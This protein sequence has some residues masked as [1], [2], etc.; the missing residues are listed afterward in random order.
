MYQPISAKQFRDNMAQVLEEVHE[1]GSEYTLI[2]R[3][4]PMVDIVPSKIK[5]TG[6]ANKDRRDFLEI[7][8]ENLGNTSNSRKI[9][10]GEEKKILRKRLVEK[11]GL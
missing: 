2:Y 4:K 9:N 5:K 6:K 7:M 8:E 1:T 10:V 3:S 11:H